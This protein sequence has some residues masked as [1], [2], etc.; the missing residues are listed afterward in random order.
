VKKKTSAGVFVGIA[1]VILVI[2]AVAVWFLF[3][4]NGGGLKDFDY[5]DIVGSY[6]GT[7][8]HG[9]YKLSGDWQEYADSQGENLDTVNEMVDEYNEDYKGDKV[10][11]QVTLSENTLYFYCPDY[12]VFFGDNS[13]TIEDFEIGNNGVANDTFEET[14]YGADIVIKYKVTL[15]ADG[16]GYRLVGNV[17]Y[18]SGMSFDYNS[19]SYEVSY[20]GSFSFDVSTEE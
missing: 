4:S 3:F 16:D 2:A 19:K 8:T 15:K 12:Y 11:I 5:E 20:S 7:V 1:A 10:D 13:I 17:T 9:A 6:T 14:Y 18:S